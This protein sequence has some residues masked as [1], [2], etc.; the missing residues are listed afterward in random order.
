MT[1]RVRCVCSGL[2]RRPTGAEEKLCRLLLVVHFYHLVKFLL[3]RF[4]HG[5]NM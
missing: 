2:T 4:Y 5:H 3:C 1:S